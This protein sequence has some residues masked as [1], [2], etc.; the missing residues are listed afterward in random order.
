MPLYAHI[1]PPGFRLMA[2]FAFAC[3]PFPDL[4]G[5]KLATIHFLLTQKGAL[6]LMLFMLFAGNVAEA[7]KA[8]HLY[9]SE[10][11]GK[12]LGRAPNSDPS[13]SFP[14]P[15]KSGKIKNITITE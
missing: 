4:A 7:G 11:I 5:Y 3:K 12:R 8:G 10:M 13:E 2:L 6:I 1:N 14:K 15:Q 9:I